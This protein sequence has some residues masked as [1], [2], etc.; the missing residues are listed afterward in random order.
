MKQCNN[1]AMKSINL[2]TT[3]V[4]TVI[5]Q[6]VSVLRRG[7]LLIYPT[8]TVYGLGVDA[9]NPSAVGKLV[10]YKSRPLGKPFS[11]A[12]AD[13]Q[14]AGKYVE[15]N[16]TAKKLYQTFLPGPLTIISNCLPPSIPSYPIVP[17][18]ASELGTLGIRIP[19]Y[20]LIIEIVKRL[21]RPITATS[22]N[23][24]YKKR[25]YQIS[26]IINYIPDRKKK[27]IDLI[28]DAGKLPRNEP[29]TVIDTTLDD[30]TVLRQ[31]DITFSSENNVLTRNEQE[32]QNIAKELWQKYERFAGKRAIIFALDGPMG[33]GK[34]QF[35]KGLARAMGIK[36]EITSPTYSLMNH[37]SLLPPPYSL[38]HVDA[39]RMESDSE[40]EDLGFAKTISDKSVIAI[41]WAD[42]VADA[43]RRYQEDAIVIW[44]KIRYGKGNDER[45]IAWEAR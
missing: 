20:P 8:E 45:W 35:I 26:D 32:T 24:A 19:D 16:A 3:P 33:A 42:R 14:M 27:L 17:G 11:V 40:L 23:Q 36:K 5:S 44:V 37:Y 38:L 2:K 18:I 7:G 13:Q 4:G 12:V 29:S 31:G 43:I 6:A 39:W 34:T 9:T 1:E 10:S 28:L 15:L 22:A 41:E 25:P 21:D 30:P